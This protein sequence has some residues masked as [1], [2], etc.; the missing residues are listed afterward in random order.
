[1]S[2]KIIPGID[3][4][5]HPRGSK[6]YEIYRY[7]YGYS[8]YPERVNP[9]MIVIPKD[10]SDVCKVVKYAKAKGLR[11]AVRSG[12]HQY[13]AASSTVGE[14]IQ[15]DMSKSFLEF[16]DRSKVD[17]TVTMGVSYAINEINKKL[18]DIGCFVPHGQCSHLHFGGHAQTGG[19]GVLGRA[20]GLLGDHIQ[21]LRIVTAGGEE[22]TL[23]RNATDLSEKE[24]FFAFL[25]G[26][27]GNYG[28]LTHL[29]LRVHR[30]TDHPNSRGLKFMCIYSKDILAELLTIKAKMA[31]QTDLLCDVDFCVTV[32]NNTPFSL[33]AHHGIDEKFKREHSEQFGNDSVAAWP[34]SIM[35][36]AQYANTLGDK[37]PESDYKEAMKW[38]DDILNVFQFEWKDPFDML[39]PRKVFF[40]HRTH[41]SMSEL[42]RE[43]VFFNVREFDLPYEKRTY[44][45]NSTTLLKDKWV[46]WVT[47]RVD[48]GIHSHHVKITLQVQHF[49]GVRSNFVTGGA[50]ADPSDTAYSWRSD[51][52]VCCC[53]NC[54]YEPEG[55]V[56][57]M[58]WQAEND[59]CVGT[60]DSVFCKEDRRLLWGSYNRQG[61]LWDLDDN[62]RFYHESEEKYLRLRAIKKAVDPE[63][64]LVPNKFCIGWNQYSQD[65]ITV[66]SDDAVN[67]NTAVSSSSGVAAVISDAEYIKGMTFR[68]AHEVKGGMRDLLPLHFETTK[69]KQ[70]QHKEGVV[71]GAS[72]EDVLPALIGVEHGSVCCVIG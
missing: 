28:I 9:G 45:S 60:T 59:K 31:A 63:G 70:K 8:S 32:V 67:A 19:Y 30:D 26:S 57:A 5:V 21:Q 10:V 48:C 47:N 71:P 53:L 42:T 58:Q 37:Q 62:W 55:R 33:A 54:F 6:D 51:A 61:E 66:L 64:V 65:P 38:L 13:S 16:E 27:P 50:D 25:G 24:W 22:K 49:G 4:L 44:M 56:E 17:G 41:R 69:K 52:T 23:S 72:G 18:G 15:I 12:G 34:A 36:Y 11:I 46:D 20:F 1:M 40:D 39:V 68:M 43:W 2:S 35:V 3:G 7:Q 29:T 14:N